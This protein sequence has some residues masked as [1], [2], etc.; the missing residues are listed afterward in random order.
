MSIF[1]T[2]V[3]C[4]VVAGVQGVPKPL[5]RSG[6]LPA[7]DEYGT[8]QTFSDLI[9]GQ[10]LKPY[11]ILCIKGETVTF[12]IGVTNVT[13]VTKELIESGA[14]YSTQYPIL[15]LQHGQNF[16]GIKDPNNYVATK[17]YINAFYKPNT[18]ACTGYYPG[19]HLVAD[20]DVP[21]VV[22]QAAWA[23]EPLVPAD[24]EKEGG[25][26]KAGYVRIPPADATIHRC[27]VVGP[28]LKLLSPAQY[29]I[30]GCPDMNPQNKRASIAGCD[31]SD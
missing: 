6:C 2:L 18:T 29:N 7:A 31:Y 12:P 15:G 17:E 22:F 1:I 16:V 24:F 23:S 8:V 26:N 10:P 21:M 4:A 11:T 9:V 14:Y 28:D 20:D 3:F 30:L 5:R 27:Q 13:D 25:F 19:G